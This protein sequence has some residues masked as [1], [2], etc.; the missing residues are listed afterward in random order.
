MQAVAT[1]FGLLPEAGKEVLPESQ[2]GGG[3]PKHSEA[4]MGVVTSTI[5]Q[6]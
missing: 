1:F 4:Y 6:E 2:L 5:C 3:N